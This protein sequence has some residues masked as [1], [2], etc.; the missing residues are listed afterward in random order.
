MCLFDTRRFRFT[1]KKIPVYKV[2]VERDTCYRTPYK[3]GF[4]SKDLPFIQESSTNDSPIHDKRD[5]TYEYGSGFVFA[6][7]SE[8]EAKEVKGNVEFEDEGNFYMGQTTEL[9]H[10]VILEGYIPAFTRYAID[11]PEGAICA[12]KMVFTK[13][14][15][16]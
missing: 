14:L 15:Q 12:R 3:C 16:S 4:I 13:V 5:G 7:I 8:K 1:L 10:F 6:C 2:V 11:P 9:A